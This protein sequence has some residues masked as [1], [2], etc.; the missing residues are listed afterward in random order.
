MFGLSE[1]SKRTGIPS[2][3]LRDWAKA[4]GL[5]L[6]AR[7]SPEAAGLPPLPKAPR[8]PRQNGIAKEQKDSAPPP[9]QSGDTTPLNAR[10]AGADRGET[11]VT[12]AGETAETPAGDYLDIDAR[13]RLQRNMIRTDLLDRI[14]D[15]LHRMIEPHLE[16]FPV[17]DAVIPQTYPKAPAV[18]FRAYAQ[19]FATL[20]KEYRLEVGE[21]TDRTDNTTT[22]RILDEVKNDHERAALKKAIEEALR[23]DARPD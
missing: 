7:L 13:L 22:T 19:A 3:T 1:A 15:A 5:D 9:A 18:A 14:Q 11:A 12:P 10:D 17:R 21:A 6:T 2:R 16:F 8:A 20:M 23:E 4:A